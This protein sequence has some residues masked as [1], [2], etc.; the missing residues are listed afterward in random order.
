MKKF[1]TVIALILILAGGTTFTA[2]SS[3]DN[4]TVTA[5]DKVG[6]LG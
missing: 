6:G 5:L 4:D 3:G 2:T 1:I